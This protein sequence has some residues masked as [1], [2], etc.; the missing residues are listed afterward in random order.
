MNT[1][2]LLHT[3]HTPGLPDPCQPARSQTE[4]S[5]FRTQ[6][7]RSLFRLAPDSNH[8]HPVY[9]AAASFPT[10]GHARPELINIAESPKPLSNQVCIPTLE[11]LQCTRL[12]SLLASPHWIPRLLL[13]ACLLST[14]TPRSSL[15]LCHPV[16]ALSAP[17]CPRLLFSCSRL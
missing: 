1:H 16:L 4:R 2:T 3:H 9:S 15:S 14:T 17:V 13:S 10:P 6:K 8:T 7:S 12:V 11:L 5:A